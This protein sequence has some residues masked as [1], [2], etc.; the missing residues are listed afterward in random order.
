M[1]S[2]R[3]TNK[4]RLIAN[5]VP[6]SFKIIN[7]IVTNKFT[8]LRWCIFEL[9]SSRGILSYNTAI[10]TIWYQINCTLNTLMHVPLSNIYDLMKYVNLA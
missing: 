10:M 1:S 2:I 3:Y 5:I 8:N 9:T 7:P 4:T 6:T